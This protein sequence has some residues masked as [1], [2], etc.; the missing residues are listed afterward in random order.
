MQLFDL[1][2]RTALIMGG[3][4]KMGIEFAK[5]LLTAGADI[6]ICDY[7]ENDNKDL[8]SK[9]NEKFSEKILAL[10]CDASNKS[11]L[12]RTF[13]KIEKFKGSLD[14]LIYNVMS[15]PNGYFNDFEEYNESSWDKVLASN[16]KGAFLTT[17]HSI[18]L[19]KKTKNA[20]SII[21]TSST[22]GIVGP[23]QRLYEGLSAEDNIYGGGLA[24][25]SPPA[26]AASKSGL[27]GLMRYLASRYGRNRI[28]VNC[29]APGG[30]YDQQETKFVDRYV[31]KTMLGRMANW[32]DYNGAILF[33]SSDASKYMTGSVLIVDGGYTAW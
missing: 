17:Q 32:S 19:M 16:L 12:E 6:I 26:Y 29:L 11:Q 8:I 3:A 22:Y 10:E 4:G 14:I 25:S 31:E 13:K 27:H 30:V 24:L 28:R 33:L 5:T 23:D 9:F 7:F 21:L 20:G 1:T 15:K 18:K 2:G